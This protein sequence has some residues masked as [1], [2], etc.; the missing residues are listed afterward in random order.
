VGEGATHLV[1]DILNVLVSHGLRRQQ[2]LAADLRVLEDCAGLCR[3]QQAAHDLGIMGA[4]LRGQLILALNMRALAQD[5][6][7]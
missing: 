3:Q 5:S 7:P 1:S 4:P 6:S 2:N